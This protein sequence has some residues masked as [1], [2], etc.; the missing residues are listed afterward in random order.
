MTRPLCGIFV[1]GAA[2]RM[3]G[4]PKGL[5]PVDHTG[6]PIVLCLARL[7]RSLDLRV[8]LVGQHAAFERFDLPQLADR[9]A[10]VGPLGGLLALLDAAEGADVIALACDMPFVSPSFLQRLLAVDLHEADLA[11]A[12]TAPDAPL[13]TFLARYRPATVKP[14]LDQALAEGERSLQ[15]IVRTLRVVTLRLTDEERQV[16]KDWDAWEDVPEWARP[17]AE[18][19]GGSRAT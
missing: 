8:A 5:L 13:E 17:E 7:A 6:E 15:R 12:Q 1:G 10:G 11:A 4:Y 14:R 16:S 2:R 19:D 18:A 9:P 3:G